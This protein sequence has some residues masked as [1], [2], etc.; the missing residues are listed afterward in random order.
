MD[1]ATLKELADWVDTTTIA[2]VILEELEEQ[3]VPATLENGQ[4]VWLD[5]LEE[6]HHIATS[7]I[8]GLVNRGELPLKP[9]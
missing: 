3:G 4:K 8:V 1:K 5:A 7:S 6:L 2:E 9:E